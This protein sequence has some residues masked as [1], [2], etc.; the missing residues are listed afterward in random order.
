MMDMIKVAVFSAKEYD[1][2]SF[3]QH[4]DGRVAFEY[5]DVKLTP[6]TVELAKGFDAICAFVN[7]ELNSNV[8]TM[9]NEVGVNAIALRCAGFNNVDLD[10]ANKLGIRVARVP[11]YSPEA[12]AEHTIALM[13]TLNRKLHKAYNRTK[14]DNFNLNGLLGFNIYGK[15]IGLVGTGKI[16][17]AT[18]KILRGFGA[19]LLAYDPVI[20]SEAASLG[21]NYVSFNELL[22]QADIISLHC[23]LND[24][25]FHLLNEQTIKAMKPGVM[26]VNTGRGALIDSKCLINNLKSGHIGHLALDVYEQE[27]ELFFDD[28]SSA[29]VQDD[30]FQRLLTF[31]NVLITGHQGFFTQEAL[32][33]IA[34]TTLQN[35]RCLVAG[36]I[37]DNEITTFNVK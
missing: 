16:G 19:K 23:P 32:N 14:E 4:N 18:A 34:T 26:I 24:D 13:L 37:S 1:K 17:L 6:K 11:A 7:D 3:E 36:D 27:S 9:L 25:T 30:I 5:F 35:I 20:N 8:L 28:H 29:I 21:V 33:Q 31:P 12:V 2:E 10:A 22:Q 15:T